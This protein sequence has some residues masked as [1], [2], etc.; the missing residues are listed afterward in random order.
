MKKLFVNKLD[1]MQEQKLVKAEAKNFWFLYWLLFASIIIQLIINPNLKSILAEFVVLLASSIYCVFSSL[2]IN[3]W[4][5]SF[6]PSLKSNILLSCLSGF[7]ATA[8]TILNIYIQ[9]G[10][11]A[12]KYQIFTFILTFILSFTLLTITSKIFNKNEDKV[13]NSNE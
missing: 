12:P 7:I 5:R 6:K 3:I 8:I 11:F 1:E 4:S 9:S 10:A 2:K 13:E